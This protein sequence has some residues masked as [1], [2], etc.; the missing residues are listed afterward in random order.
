MDCAKPCNTLQN[1]SE[2]T[3]KCWQKTSYLNDYKTM[4]VRRTKKSDR[5]WYDVKSGTIPRS[6]YYGFFKIQWSIDWSI[7]HIVFFALT[8]CYA[9]YSGKG[10]PLKT[11]E[12]VIYFGSCRC[13]CFSSPNYF[14]ARLRSLIMDSEGDLGEPGSLEINDRC[15][16]WWCGKV[17][18]SILLVP[19]SSE[20][21]HVRDVFEKSMLVLEGS[22]IK[23]L[24]L[25][26]TEGCK[27]SVYIDA[28][29]WAT[30]TLFSYE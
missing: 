4:Q 2:L 18:R 11:P 28:L 25:K 14:T 15:C 12:I 20:R 3:K 6:H 13:I 16:C 27:C 30:S 17:Q 5:T 21:N 8:R 26:L 24:G 29:L 9:D 1:D 10:T 23:E 22:K 7:D 19:D